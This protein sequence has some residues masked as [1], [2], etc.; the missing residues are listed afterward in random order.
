[1]PSGVVHRIR[2][3]A[4]DALTV[5]TRTDVCCRF[6]LLRCRKMPPFTAGASLPPAHVLSSAMGARRLSPVDVIEAFWRASQAQDP[7][8][9]AFVEVY[10]DDARLAAE[11]PTRRSARATRSGRCTAMPIALKD[12]IEIE[13]RV[14][15]GG[16]EGLARPQARR[17]RHAGAAAA[18]RRA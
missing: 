14:D 4:T 17:H 9:Q 5:V 1:M 3:P 15:T 13:G 18:S 6:Q 12:L 10:A 2:L 11:A 8:L 16:C 7:K